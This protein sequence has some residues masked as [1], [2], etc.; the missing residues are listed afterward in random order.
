MLSLGFLIRLLYIS[1]TPYYIRQN[2]SY[3]LGVNGGHLYYIEYFFN[4]F[5]KIPDFDPSS[6]WQFYHPPFHHIVSAVWMKINALFGL[7]YER[8][9]ENIQVLTMLYS[10]LITI[11]AHKILV[12]L[13]IK[14][15]IISCVFPILVFHPH[16]IILSGS[17][18]NDVLSILLMFLSI[19]YVLKW[20]K[21]STLKNILLV[22]L[23]I[24]LGC[25][26]KFSSILVSPAIG[27]LFFHK[28]IKERN[29]AFGKYAKQFIIFGLTCIP[30][31]LSWSTYL[32]VKWGLELGYVPR[33]SVNTLITQSGIL[34]RLFTADL[35]HLTHP[36]VI[37]DKPNNDYNIF[38]IMSKTAMFGETNLGKTNLLYMM[39]LLLLYINILLMIVTFIM[40][41]R[42]LVKKNKDN[43]I[44]NTF[45]ITLYATFMVSYISFC[46]GYPN[47][48][49]PNFRY[50]VPTLISSIYSTSL[51]LDG[52]KNKTVEIILYIL[53]FLF[54]LLSSSMYITLAYK[55]GF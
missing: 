47:I 44:K 18:N 52:N 36:F 53:I 49:T 39:S 29:I 10:T 48:S 13:N 6:V 41:I 23:F 35:G 43:F 27:F 34:E 30:I 26:T 4:N 7:S 46:F 9:V 1:Y 2:D 28:L 45:L 24:S 8:I 33:A 3:K 15:K 20:Y 38:M 5:I 19:L 14:E 22:S 16:L 50:I 25:L 11:V 21:S 40:I 37:W 51:F 17:I 31:S 42:T 54:C 55:G 32:S 12:E